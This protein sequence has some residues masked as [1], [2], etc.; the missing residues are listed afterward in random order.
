[1]GVPLD[2]PEAAKRLH[3]TDGPDLRRPGQGQRLGPTP[4]AG[5]EGDRPAPLRADPGLAAP[6]RRD[7]AAVAR[8]PWRQ[9]R[10]RRRRAGLARAAA[11]R[12]RAHPRRGLPLPAA[13]RLELHLALVAA[14][15]AGLPQH[16]EGR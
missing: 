11:P 14:H 5:P 13:V 4:A 8:P 9:T 16:A 2:D 15:A 7:A 10:C 1:G 3:R 6:P 12:L